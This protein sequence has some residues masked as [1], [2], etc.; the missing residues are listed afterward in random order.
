MPREIIPGM[1]DPV[2]TL[3]EIFGGKSAMARELDL[4]ASTI[5]NWKRFGIPYD[6]RFRIDRLLR[7]SGLPEDVFKGAMKALEAEWPRDYPA[8]ERPPWWDADRAWPPAESS[9]GR[10]LAAVE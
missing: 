10:R 4:G 3:A 2:E 8:A 9:A 1:D 5:S 7:G 6:Q